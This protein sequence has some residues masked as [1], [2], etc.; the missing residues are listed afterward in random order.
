[1]EKGRAFEVSVLRLLR[2]RCEVVP[3]GDS[4]Q[5]SRDPDKARE[6]LEAMKAGVEVIH[7]AVLHDEPT[8][9][10]GMPDLLVRGDVLERLFPGCVCARARAAVR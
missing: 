8:Q 2:N 10:Y 1:M 7:C 9:T 4:A 3:I 6:T 5:D